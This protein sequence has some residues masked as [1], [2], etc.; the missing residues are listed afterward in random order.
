VTLEGG[1]PPAQL[2]ERASGDQPCLRNQTASYGGRWPPPPRE[3]AATG[4]GVQPRERRPRNRPMLPGQPCCST[5]CL[6]EEAVARHCQPSGGKEAGGCHR[7]WPSPVL[8]WRADYAR[9][10]PTLPLAELAGPSSGRRRTG[11]AGLRCGL[12]WNTTPCS[13]AHDPGWN[14]L[15]RCC[16]PTGKPLPLA[17]NSGWGRLCSAP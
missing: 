6:L 4:G 3:L 12:C 5:L 7:P 14:Y 17:L 9:N 2:D 16:S 11:P 15:C 13:A 1:T 10:L 8:F